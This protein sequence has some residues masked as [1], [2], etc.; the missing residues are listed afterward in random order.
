MSERYVA[1]WLDIFGGRWSETIGYGTRVGQ[2]VEFLFEYPDGPFRTS[3][4]LGS[5]GW[6]VLMRQR[7]AAGEWQT[8]GR[9]V[10]RPS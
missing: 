9:W 10:L 3:F 8:F 2:T 5:Q 6:T 4:A 7:T 1:H